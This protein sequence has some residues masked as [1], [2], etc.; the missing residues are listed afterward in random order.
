VLLPGV[1]EPGLEVSPADLF[2]DGIAQ[3]EIGDQLPQPGIL[4]LHLF[5][6]LGLIDLHAAILFATAV[7]GLF[8]DTD[9][10]YSCLDRL[11]SAQQYLDLPSLKTYGKIS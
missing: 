11:A 6:A 9:L 8:G 2:Q 4:F 3:R 7:V 5:K 10:S 1:D